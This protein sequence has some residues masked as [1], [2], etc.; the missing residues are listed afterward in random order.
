ML[1][2]KFI[3]LLSVT[4]TASS[5]LAT[6]VMAVSC[7][8]K[9][10]DHSETWADFKKDAQ[11]ETILNI[12]QTSKPTG[13]SDATE[14]E[15]KGATFVAD[16][17]A[18]KITIDITRT[19]ELNSWTASFEIDYV[20]GKNY[21]V[22]GWE[23][24]KQPSENPNSW[25]FFKKDALA[26]TAA[27]L[28]TQARSSKDFATFKWTYGTTDQVTWIKTDQAE[29]DT[30]GAKD[31]TKD[32]Y[33]G[34]KG[35]PISDDTNHKVTAIISKKGK[36]GAYD[37]DPIAATA[38][39]TADQ[40]YKISDWTFKQTKQLISEEKAKDMFNT[41][42]ALADKTYKVFLQENW[43]TINGDSS[44]DQKANADG[45]AHLAYVAPKNQI[46]EA[47][48]TLGYPSSKSFGNVN[49]N[50]NSDPTNHKNIVSIIKIG[51]TSG[52]S[53][54]VLTLSFSFKYSNGKDNTGGVNP[55]SYTW[56]G[57]VGKK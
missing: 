11:A 36:N 1:N 21:N 55:L 53:V 25:D 29:F 6:D 42:A 16:D 49:S 18:Q 19:K 17:N 38:T 27:D 28:I 20:S 24:S 40:T 50:F 7:G 57:T 56:S 48:K 39:Y 4:L 8:K 47:L 51:F 12:V 41:E 26:V 22:S 46:Q 3:K 14:S 31:A 30:F 2:K 32:S 9:V 15:L 43:M 45:I 52:S 35:K 10:K 33:A 37:S 5:I 23:C 54:S 44:E 13:W 34:M